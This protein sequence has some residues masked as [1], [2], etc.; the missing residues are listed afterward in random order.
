VFPKARIEA[1]ATSCLTVSDSFNR[2]H[3]IC[4]LL[5]VHNHVAIVDVSVMLAAMGDRLDW[6][7]ICG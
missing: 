7:S 6:S 4:P 1:V 5:H 3:L 2:V